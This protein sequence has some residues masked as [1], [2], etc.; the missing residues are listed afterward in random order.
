[1]SQLL[2]SMICLVAAW[3]MWQH[4]TTAQSCA[5]CGTFRGHRQDCPYDLDQR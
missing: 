4:Y 3:K 5:Y 2:V 1:M